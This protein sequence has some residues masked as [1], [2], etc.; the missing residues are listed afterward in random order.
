MAVT[1]T[2]AGGFQKGG[3]GYYAF[4][5]DNELVIGEN[6]PHEGGEIYRGTFANASRVLKTLEKEATKL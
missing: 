3:Y 2:F 4:I 1:H 5:E 6:W